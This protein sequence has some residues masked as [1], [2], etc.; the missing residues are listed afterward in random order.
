[1]NKETTI[2]EYIEKM[3]R[4]YEIKN[5]G[6]EHKENFCIEIFNNIISEEKVIVILK[7][8][9]YVFL[10][11]H[12]GFEFNLGYLRQNKYF[13]KFFYDFF[14]EKSDSTIIKYSIYE[15]LQKG[16]EV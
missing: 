16:S 1:M 7:N 11:K 9:G 8:Y 10:K 3:L 12:K 2:K 13:K 15:F 6:I 14:K 5:K 4:E